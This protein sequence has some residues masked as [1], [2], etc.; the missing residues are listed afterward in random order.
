MC[1]RLVPSW[2]VSCTTPR[3]LPLPGV[4]TGSKT[5]PPLPGRRTK[6]RRPNPSPTNLRPQN[7]RAEWLAFRFCS[8]YFAVLR[9]WKSLVFHHEPAIMGKFYH[10]HRRIID[11]SHC[12]TV[13]HRRPR[14]LFSDNQRRIFTLAGV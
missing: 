13:Y 12:R 2:I 5:T 7:R 11:K 6:T 1:P 8:F 3:P 14:C 10:D 4:V 9:L